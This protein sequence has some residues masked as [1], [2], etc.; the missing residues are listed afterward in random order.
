VIDN[1]PLKTELFHECLTGSSGPTSRRQKVRIP[2]DITV[3]VEKRVLK[4]ISDSAKIRSS[5]ESDMQTLN[6]S[7][8][9]QKPEEGTIKLCCTLTPGAKNVGKLAAK[10][11]AACSE[12]IIGH[13]DKIAVKDEKISAEIWEEYVKKAKSIKTS[14]VSVEMDQASFLLRLVGLDTAVNEYLKA[15]AEIRNKLL[16]E[17][18]KR[19]SKIFESLTS[20][21]PNQLQLLKALKFPSGDPTV[22]K[23]LEIN[24]DDHQVSFQGAKDDINQAKIRMY[25]LVNNVSTKMSKVDARKAKFL[26]KGHAI[27][28]FKE[29]FEKKKL[30]V[31]WSIKGQDLEVSGITDKEINEALS[32]LDSEIQ[33]AI[34][35]LDVNQLVLMKQE[36]W[37]GFKKGLED[38]FK[39]NDVTEDMHASA[40]TVVSTRE[41]I[42][43]IENEIRDFLKHHT[44]LEQFI[45]MEEG[46][47][48]YMEQF[49]SQEMDN[50][51][52][53]LSAEGVFIEVSQKNN[54]AGI[55]I[56][57]TKSG[58]E[59]AVKSLFEIQQPILCTTH[60]SDLYGVLRYFSS[61]RGR[62]S[63][64]KIENKNKVIIQISKQLRSSGASGAIGG[65]HRAG[66]VKGLVEKS[67]V[68]VHGSV[69]KV[70]KGDVV[71]C[72]VIA[73]VI[74]IGEDL[75]HTDGAAKVVIE[76]GKQ[77]SGLNIYS[78]SFAF[79]D[80]V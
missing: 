1:Q 75:K 38:A 64:E 23:D 19:K 68:S 61:H 28:Y 55:L 72:R 48:T 40:V 16:E 62:E 15:A 77:C 36:I 34:I 50:I 39:T 42:E 8:Q 18:A 49:F 54:S 2:E 79:L 53:Q 31:F 5:I 43:Q 66:G 63:K 21:K 11:E 71:E 45:P 14:G 17:L 7:I 26:Q 32:L 67:A 3:P 20:L 59:K 73:L 10:W 74:P 51:Q 60:E 46:K 29:L 56:R 24:I 41:S 76:A 6:C 70:V 37:K 27:D 12:Q 52:S 58:L 25:E 22:S 65:V 4:F 9:W 33:C 69:T 35:T 30:K 57:G 44:I 80:T 78:K 13:L 47:A